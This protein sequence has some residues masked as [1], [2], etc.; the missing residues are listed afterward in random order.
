[1]TSRLAV[2]GPA[3]RKLA[4]IGFLY[5]FAFSGKLTEGPYA[6][7][8]NLIVIAIVIWPSTSTKLRFLFMHVGSTTISFVVFSGNWLIYMWIKLGDPLFP[9]F[10][11]IFESPYSGVGGLVNDHRFLPHNVW[12]TLIYPFQW[13][14]HPTLVSEVPF[15]DPVFDASFGV[16][17]IAEITLV[18][19]SPITSR[20]NQRRT[21]IGLVAS[22]AFMLLYLLWVEIWGI[23]R[24]LVVLSEIGPTIAI[25]ALFSAFQAFPGRSKSGVVPI[26]TLTIGFAMLTFTEQ[27]ANFGRVPYV[28]KYFSLASPLN[29]HGQ[30][31]L[32]TDPTTN[33]EYS[34]PLLLNPGPIVR[35]NY[36]MPGLII[37]S[38]MWRLVKLAPGTRVVL[39]GTTSDGGSA[40]V[41][42]TVSSLRMYE[43]PTIAIGTCSLVGARVGSVE[44]TKL[45]ECPGLIK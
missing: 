27:P 2:Q 44:S 36:D 43:L 26:A 24:Y 30:E 25:F 41:T 35:I 16:I 15:H 20:R 10:F 33:F 37:P 11:T 40:Q 31:I 3:P 14:A 12:D 17:G 13:L 6:L 42:S 9:F 5:G 4:G 29:I 7:I 32:L 1:M 22:I 23:Y 19:S 45:A 21:L 28:P 18:V 39:L 38:V 8:G 34:L